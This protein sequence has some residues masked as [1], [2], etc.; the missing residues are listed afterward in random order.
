[1]ARPKRGG[2]NHWWQLIAFAVSK[3]HLTINE[4]ERMDLVQLHALIV[5]YQRLMSRRQ[6]LDLDDLS[7]MGW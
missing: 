2:R 1:M 5:G 3:L 7:E 4:L 6:A